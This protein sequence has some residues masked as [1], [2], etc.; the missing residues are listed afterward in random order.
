MNWTEILF[1]WTKISTQKTSTCLEGGIDDMVQAKFW[2]VWC[3]YTGKI[4]SSGLKIYHCSI[5]V[6]MI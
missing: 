3:E 1:Y 5:S 2:L 4:R 6:L